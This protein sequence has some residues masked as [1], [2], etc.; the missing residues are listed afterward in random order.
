[1]FQHYAA[2]THMSVREN[3]AFGLQHPQAPAAE[4]R[5]A[6]DE[7]LG[8]VGPDQVGRPATRASSPVASASAWRWRAPWPS[9]PRCCCS[10]S[11]SA[12]WTRTSGPSCAAWL[13]RLHDEQ[14]VTTVLVTHDQ[15][16]A[17]EVA[18]RI[19]V[20]NE[21][22]IEQVGSPREMYDEPANEF[23]MGFLGPVS[24]AR[25]AA[26]PPPRRHRLARR[27]ADD[28]VEAMVAR[29]VH[30]GFEVRIE[31]ELPGG[32]QARAQLTRAQAEE[33]ELDA[34]TSSTC[35]RRWPTG[36]AA[37]AIDHRV[38]HASGSSASRSIVFG[39]RPLATSATVT[40]STTLRRL[41][42]TAIQTRGSAAEVP[43]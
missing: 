7:L 23:V 21:G 36:T 26:G 35:A 6:V 29:V 40:C 37:A 24:Q 18:D 27:P 19:A 10:T 43:G 16:E 5:G 30:L 22:R 1:M 15:E 8:L 2:F 12:R 9:S 34:A 14:G 32:E 17:M 20:M 3:V 42:R 41:A 4:V 25:G 33:L 31:L 13:R 28:A 39:N 38:I 11:R